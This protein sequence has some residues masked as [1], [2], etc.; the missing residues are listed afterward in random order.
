MISSTAQLEDFL[1]AYNSS[2]AEKICAIDTEA[3]SIHRHKEYICLI[4]FNAGND[5]ILIDPLAI[6]DLAPL[7]VYLKD[8]TV[9]MHGAD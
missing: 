3:D 4:K 9:W 5:C 8:A 7:D 2:A 1:A 6:K